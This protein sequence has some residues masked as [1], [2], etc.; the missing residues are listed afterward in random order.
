M[1]WLEAV[2]A[3]LL[4]PEWQGIKRHT[5]T[6]LLDIDGAVPVEATLDEAILVRQVSVILARLCNEN[7]DLPA[8]LAGREAGRLTETEAFA[9][10]TATRAHTWD[11]VATVWWDG[12]RVSWWLT[13]HDCDVLHRYELL[14]LRI[15]TANRQLVLR[16]MGLT[17]GDAARWAVEG[18]A[19]S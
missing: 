16:A 9:L 12:R 2:H 17:E 4:P 18:R 6:L 7:C 19:D 13:E 10:I 5:Y 3:L 1:N 8:H 15:Y 14:L 11:G